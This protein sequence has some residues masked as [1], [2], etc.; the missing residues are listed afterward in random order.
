[1]QNIRPTFSPFWLLFLPGLLFI[2]SATGLADPFAELESEV[3]KETQVESAGSVEAVEEEVEEAQAVPSAAASGEGEGLS[4]AGET[5]WGDAPDGRASIARLRRVEGTVLLLAPGSIRRERIAENHIIYEKDIVMTQSRSSATLE[6]VDGSRIVLAERA[7]LEARAAEQFFQQ[8]GIA[9]FDV[10][11]RTGETRF[12][13]DTKFA[14]IG[15][16]GTEFIVNAEPFSGRIALNEGEIEIINPND[17]EYAI[18]E[19][20][21]LSYEDFARQRMQDFSS[22]KKK[23]VEEFTEYKKSFSLEAGK[24]LIFNGNRVQ[25]DDLEGED[26][27]LFERFRRLR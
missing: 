10:S 12:A 23:I 9:Y 16:K 21:P 20:Q 8:E 13:V 22:Y 3:K 27:A 7:R 26:S 19:R 17:E 6:V 11:R 24:R 2:V 15:V 1:M 14:M 4:E 25:Q 5:S 18:T